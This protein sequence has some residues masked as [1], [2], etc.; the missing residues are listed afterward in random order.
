MRNTFV[1]ALGATALCFIVSWIAYERGVNDSARLMDSRKCLL[2][3]V[4]VLKHLADVFESYKQPVKK[5]KSS[6]E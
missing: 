3:I 1:A 6:V 4:D 5:V 2:E